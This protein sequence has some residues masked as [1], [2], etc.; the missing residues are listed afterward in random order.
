MSGDPNPK[1]VRVKQPTTMPQGERRVLYRRTGGN[2]DWCGTFMGYEDMDAHH[3][4]KRGP[5]TWALSNIAGVHHLCHVLNPGSI[6]MNPK[7]AKQ[8]GFIIPVEQARLFGLGP[9]EINGWL[10]TLND[11]GTRTTMEV[12]F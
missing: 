5:G 3:R 2:C 7:L 4:L 9:I 6:H 1:P 8:R 12:P 10:W 11:D